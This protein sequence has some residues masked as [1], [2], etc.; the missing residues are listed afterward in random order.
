MQR[1]ATFEKLLTIIVEDLRQADVQTHWTTW[2]ETALEQ[3]KNRDPAG[4]RYFLSAH[5][6]MG[7]FNDWAP[8]SKIGWDA[9]QKART[10]AGD[11]LRR[12]GF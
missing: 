3:V 6:G 10:V 1:N 5:G 9:D 12:H 7:S 8:L 11:L 2:M 4:V